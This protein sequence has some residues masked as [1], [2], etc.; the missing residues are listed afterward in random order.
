MIRGLVLIAALSLTACGPSSSVPA[1]PKVTSFT[2]NP[3]YLKELTTGI[4]LADELKKNKQLRQDLVSAG[5]NLY[6]MSYFGE[7]RLLEITPDSQGRVM[8]IKILL[9]AYVPYSLRSGITDKLSE[10][11]GKPITF[12]CSTKSFEMMSVPFKEELC[13]ITHGS[14]R[15]ELETNEPA[16]RRPADISEVDWYRLTSVSLTLKDTKLLS[17]HKV[18]ADKESARRR[19]I[20]DEAAKKDL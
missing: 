15:L 9:G 10:T 11:N 4:V 8:S 18:E 16:V 20:S 5:Q 19:N 14:Q 17:A 3:I 6:D 12:D 2:N 7:K 13:V 1:A